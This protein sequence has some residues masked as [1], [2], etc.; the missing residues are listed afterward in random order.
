[1]F[2]PF[3]SSLHDFFHLQK[4]DRNGFQN[5][6]DVQPQAFAL[7][8]ADIQLDHFIESRLILAAYL[9]QPREAWQRFEPLFLP[10]VIIGVFKGRAWSWPYDTH[11]SAQDVQQLR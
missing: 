3:H 5:N 7:H 1:M 4:N 11:F 8:V 6:E 2:W 9:P 10:R